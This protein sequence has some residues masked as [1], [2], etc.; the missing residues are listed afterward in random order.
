MTIIALNYYIHLILQSKQKFIIILFIYGLFYIM[1]KNTPLIEC[2][3][4]NNELPTIAEAK[5]SV[6]PSE[7]VI[8]LRRNIQAYAGSI[9]SKL[10]EK[11]TIISSLKSEIEQI[12]EDKYSLGYELN[13]QYEHHEELYN[14]IR[15]LRKKNDKLQ[16]VFSNRIEELEREITS[17]N[18]ELLEEISESNILAN[19]LS[20]EKNHVN[21]LLK[22]LARKEKIIKVLNKYNER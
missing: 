15:T 19:E 11:D 2:M 13:K 18:D 12:T 7:Q 22:T 4:E 6:R 3:T 21:D 20:K 8:A 10:E 14:R 17:L 5:E 16:E 9:A 1:L